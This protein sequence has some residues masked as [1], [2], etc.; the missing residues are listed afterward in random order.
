[1]LQAHNV[2]GQKLVQVRPGCAKN[3]GP[4]RDE[5]KW[6]HAGRVVHLCQHVL[7]P[8][9]LLQAAYPVCSNACQPM[10]PADDT[11]AFWHIMSW[12]TELEQALLGH[13]AASSCM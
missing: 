12:Y 8:A 1:M 3:E 7:T 6:G 9:Q 13:P 10:H 2:R 11:H 4:A 5:G